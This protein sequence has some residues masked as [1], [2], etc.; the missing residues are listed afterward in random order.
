MSRHA[1]R[2]PN[3]RRWRLEWRA[4]LALDRPDPFSGGA[5][6][7]PWQRNGLEDILKMA[8]S[9]PGGGRFAISHGNFGAGE[10]KNLPAR[11]LW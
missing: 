11:M 4:Q 8:D 1:I 2:L 7:S 5:F 3:A 6:Y 10:R 9:W